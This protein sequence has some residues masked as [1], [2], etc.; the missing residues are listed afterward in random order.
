MYV[1]RLTTYDFRACRYGI[2]FFIIS[3]CAEKAKG[4]DGF[5][6]DIQDIFIDA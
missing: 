4:L 5:L 1:T 3:S 6:T 2:L